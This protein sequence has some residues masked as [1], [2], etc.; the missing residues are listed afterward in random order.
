MLQTYILVDNGKTPTE[1]NR[2][3]ADYSI[4][5]KCVYRGTAR[6]D[7]TSGQA[8]KRLCYV[9]LGHG[10]RSAYA[11]FLNGGY[12]D[13]TGHAKTSALGAGRMVRLGTYGDPAAVPSH[14]WDS[15]LWQAAGHTAYTHQSG[16]GVRRDMMMTSADDIHRARIAW[17]NGNRTFR[18]VKDYSEM[19]KANEIACPADTKG[20]TCLACGLCKGSANGGKSIAIKVHGAGAKHF[21][22]A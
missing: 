5:G 20:L 10:P 18:V 12:E 7:A 21:K 2:T 6:P 16:A 22:S 1:N 14:V 11:S 13:L 19:D 9:N 4:C 8:D 3:G 17:S 15:L